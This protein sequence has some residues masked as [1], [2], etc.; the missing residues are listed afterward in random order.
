[1]MG[2]FFRRSRKWRL[3]SLCRWDRASAPIYEASSRGGGVPLLKTLLSNRCVNE[4][5]YCGVRV[6]SRSGC[7]RW[8]PEKLALVAYTL[9]KD[10]LIRGLFLSSA[11][12]GDPDYVVEE[13]L[14]VVEELRSMGYTGYIHLRL[15]PGVS[16]CLIREAVKLVDRVGVNLEA[17]RSDVF[18]E[19]C[20]D[21]GDFSQDVF[22]RLEWIVEEAG[23]QGLRCGVDTQLVVG[24]VEDD[25]LSYLRIVD[26]LY[27]DLGLRRVYFSGFEPV[28]GTPLEK[29]PPCRPSREYRLYQASFLIRDYGFTSDQLSEIL[30]DEG[31]LPNVDPKLA[32]ARRHPE[33]FPVNLNECSYMELLK[34]PHIGPSTAKKI[35]AY[36]SRR[37]FKTFKDVERAV[38]RRAARLI[39]RYVEPSGRG[40]DRL[41]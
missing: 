20:P 36:R 2:H 37:G 41:G 24:A 26:E 21:K 39:A 16:R 38:G 29:R 13:E 17:P 11:M 1:M 30:D 12:E 25:D 27:R 18:S 23:R 33:L 19:I 31:M 3:I 22:G 8:R 10:G 34:V 4:C 9:W 5:R 15:M 32:Y 40:L 28:P 35:M 7:E 6:S 14:R